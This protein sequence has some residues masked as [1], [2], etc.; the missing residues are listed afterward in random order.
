MCAGDYDAVLTVVTSPS[1]I[2]A[3]RKR[4]DVREV[5]SADPRTPSEKAASDR[6]RAVLARYLASTGRPS[7]QAAVDAAL[8]G[9]VLS[10][11]L[12]RAVN[13]AAGKLV[14]TSVPSAVFVQDPAPP[15]QPV[16]H[17]PT[18]EACWRDR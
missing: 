6:A 13:E 14:A 15:A 8:T 18:T 1:R 5:A 17:E 2:A 3:W 4:S 10:T 11:K 16:A 7:D 12:P 9:F